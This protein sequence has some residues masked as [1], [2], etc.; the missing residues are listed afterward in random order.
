MPY[1]LIDAADG[2]VLGPVTDEQF[3]DLADS[4]EEDSLADQDYYL[5][6]DT[7][8]MLEERNVAEGLVAVLKA[9][10]GD[11]AEMDITWQEI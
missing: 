10:L 9:A 1:Q 5:N 2:R 8:E 4:L 3:Q 7:V 11:R 6:L